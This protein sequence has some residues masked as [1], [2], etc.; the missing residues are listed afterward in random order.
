MAP[1]S[2][3]PGNA[4]LVCRVRIENYSLLANFYFTVLESTNTRVNVQDRTGC[5][6][7]CINKPKTSWD[8]AFSEQALTST[9]NH[10][11]LPNANWS[12]AIER[13]YL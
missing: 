3:V 1:L 11:K 9:D 7:L 12:I 6:L 13:S 4:S 10:W 2:I 8:C 5:D